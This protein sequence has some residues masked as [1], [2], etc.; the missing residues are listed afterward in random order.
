ML[1]F[2]SMIV[3]Y[4]CPA[5]RH[6]GAG[7]PQDVGNVARR[8]YGYRRYDSRDGV[9]RVESGTETESDAGCQSRG[10]GPLNHI[11]VTAALAH[12]CTSVRS[13]QYPVNN[14]R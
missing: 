4:F 8:L 5:L 6:S 3:E 12:P 1:V 13:D 2:V 14:V 11:H 9:G 10:H 7:D